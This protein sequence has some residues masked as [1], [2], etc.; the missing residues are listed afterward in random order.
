MCRFKNQM[1]K[2]LQWIG[3]FLWFLPLFGFTDHEF[4]LPG[5]EGSVDASR[6]EQR[7]KEIS[8]VTTAPIHAHCSYPVFSG[9]GVL[10]KYV[11]QYLRREAENRFGCF[12]KAE[13]FSEEVYDEEC[14]LSYDFVPIYHAN[15]LISSWG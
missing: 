3:V 1:F 2:D 11:N 10:A 14:E 4:T 8:F 15:G 13:I 5:C 12:V 9:E 7:G 6:Y